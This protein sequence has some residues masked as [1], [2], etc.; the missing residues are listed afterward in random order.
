MKVLIYFICF[1][2][3]LGIS[4]V[5][6]QESADMNAHLTF[7]VDKKLLKQGHLKLRLTHY[8][9]FY[10]YATEFFDKRIEVDINDTLQVLH[11]DMPSGISMIRIDLLLDN[12]PH[13]FRF[14]H[15]LFLIEN[16]DSLI[17][18][19]SDRIRSSGPGSD[20]N[21]VRSNLRLVGDKESSSWLYYYLSNEDIDRFYHVYNDY[22]DAL[23][24]RKT[25]YLN[26]QSQHY[27]LSE[28]AYNY[29]ADEIKFD[30]E[31]R[32]LKRLLSDIEP[33]APYKDVLREEVRLQFNKIKKNAFSYT[34]NNHAGV[35]YFMDVVSG[36][37]YMDRFLLNGDTTEV[38]PEIDVLFKTI[39]SL[40]I[41]SSIKDKLITFLF[42]RFG[43][44]ATDGVKIIDSAINLV[45]DLSMK[46][47]LKKLN[48]RRFKQSKIYPFKLEDVEG[49]IYTPESFSGKKVVLDFWF[50]GCTGCASLHKYLVQFENELGS[51]DVIFA[52]VN[53]D[54]KRER[55][56]SGLETGKYTEPDGLN[57]RVVNDKPNILSYYEFIS[58]P[59]LLLMDE[60]GNL[61]SYNVPKPTNDDAKRHFKELLK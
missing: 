33:G 27:N 42:A 52:T 13:L 40:E 36:E 41:P 60:E 1:F 32:R 2:F 5:R 39:T 50:N 53:I 51:N 7:Q 20:K 44:N 58:Y 23:A 16:R 8:P 22:F 19:I 3:M 4:D 49:N 43:T 38:V 28:N 29:M 30:V 35:K 9:H 59:Q 25:N 24:Y 17:W 31:S 10:I 55:W 57:L 6:S 18:H 15:N 45:E 26:K 37:Y 54:R 48:Q 47:H 56:I 11:F 14:P 21:R 46:K 61:A 12:E 34:P